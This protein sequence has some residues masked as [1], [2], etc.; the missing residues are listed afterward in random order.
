MQKKKNKY[1]RRQI[2]ILISLVICILSFVVIFGRYL[3]N[4]IK[5]FFVKS[6]EFYFYSDKLS[7][8]TSIYEIDNWSGVDDYVITINM[9]STKNNIEAATYDIGYSVSYECTDNAIC[10]LNKTAGIISQSTNTDFFNITITPNMQLETGD[11]VIVEIEVTSTAQYKKTLKGR[12]TLVVGKENLSYQITDKSQNPYMELSITNTLSYYIVDQAFSNYT[13]GQKIDIDTYLALTD[14]E[15]KKCYSSI[16][17]IKFNPTEILFDVTNNAY[18]DATNIK[19]TT[20]DGKTYINEITIPI[21]A[22]SSRDL[23][24]YKVDVSK[25]YTYPN[26]SNTSIVTITSK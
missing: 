12:F 19:T 10:T 7:E 13:A 24:F 26:E 11:R 8:N 23:R 16:V 6:E 25:D 15:K 2:I 14:E 20:I 22:V 5:N 1:L 9:N 21:D 4:N 17:T 18:G 3:T